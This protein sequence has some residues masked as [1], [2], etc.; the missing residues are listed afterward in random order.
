VLGIREALRAS[1]YALWREAE[2]RMATF[3]EIEHRAQPATAS[4]FVSKK[5][6]SI[7]TS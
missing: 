2:D 7:G 1:R 6:R 3:A 4:I 5:Y